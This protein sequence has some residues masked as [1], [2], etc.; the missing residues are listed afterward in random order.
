MEAIQGLPWKEGVNE[1]IKLTKAF[2]T[3]IKDR[4]GGTISDRVPLVSSGVDV[5]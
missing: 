3:A 1:S 4:N 2:I 5:V